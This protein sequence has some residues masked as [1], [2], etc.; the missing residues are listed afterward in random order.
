MMKQE[1]NQKKIPRGEYKDEGERQRQGK[2]VPVN[3]K[4]WVQ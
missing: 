4:V 2:N 3:Q 1:S